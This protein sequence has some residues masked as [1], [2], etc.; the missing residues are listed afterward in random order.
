MIQPSEDRVG[1]KE[2]LLRAS[3]VTR[4]SMRRIAHATLENA[5]KEML[6]ASLQR[7]IECSFG[8]WARQVHQLGVDKRKLTKSGDVPWRLLIGKTPSSFSMVQH[9]LRLGDFIIRVQ[10]PLS[11]TPSEAA[12]ELAAAR[13]WSLAARSAAEQQPEVAFS[14]IYFGKVRKYAKSSSVSM[15]LSIRLSQPHAS[16]F[17]D[18]AAVANQ[19]MCRLRADESAPQRIRVGLNLPAPVVPG[20]RNGKL[21]W[22]ESEQIALGL[23]WS[24]GVSTIAQQWRALTKRRESVDGSAPQALVNH[25]TDGILAAIEYD[26]FHPAHGLRSKSPSAAGS[27]PVS[28]ATVSSNA[29]PF[30]VPLNRR[31][32]RLDRIPSRSKAL[33]PTTDDSAMHL[34]QQPKSSF[35]APKA[36]RST[37]AAS[38]VPATSPSQA[39][40]AGTIPACSACAQPPAWA[41][42]MMNGI[43]IISQRNSDA[44]S[45]L[46]VLLHAL[47]ALAE[48]PHSD[49]GSGTHQTTLSDH[50]KGAVDPEFKT[51]ESVRDEA[52]QLLAYADSRA[53][54]L[55]QAVAAAAAVEQMLVQ[56]L[57][58]SIGIPCAEGGSIKDR[59]KATAAHSGLR[60]M[61]QSDSASRRLSH[62]DAVEVRRMVRV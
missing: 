40:A 49:A 39:K 24:T 28:S 56:S 4:G 62:A 14:D 15:L 33:P 6:T 12:S 42:D 61:T 53:A 48:G 47:H 3:S 31:S 35:I 44:I 45:E 9:S 13:A 30:S 59:G 58:Q 36:V 41:I 54:E 43:R 32:Q 18:A 60:R 2:W 57:A 25:L 29:A 19:I 38:P 51:L 8:F 21:R 7:L 5:T 16:R 34:K 17:D 27:W 10:I 23:L 46:L 26:A 1:T 37:S 20:R 52:A 55:Q 11:L 22:T 50:S